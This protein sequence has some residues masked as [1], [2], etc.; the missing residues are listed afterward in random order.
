ML[1]DSV[2][3]TVL[4]AEPSW[5]R[6]RPPPNRTESQSRKRSLR[7]AIWEGHGLTPWSVNYHQYAEREKRG[8]ER[9]ILS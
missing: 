5:A 4:C 7:L 9:G 1:C 8:E 2:V 3:P 6:A